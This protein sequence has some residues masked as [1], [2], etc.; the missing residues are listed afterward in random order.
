MF[1]VL[2][3]KMR[4]ALANAMNVNRTHKMLAFRPKT[5]VNILATSSHHE[6]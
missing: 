2:S 1:I 6:S 5:K 4:Q 3:P